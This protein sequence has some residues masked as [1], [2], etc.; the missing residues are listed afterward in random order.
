PA[1]LR[2]LLVLLVFG[3]GV[4]CAVQAGK[5]SSP[6]MGFGAA[7]LLI[8]FSILLLTAR[9]TPT[10]HPPQILLFAGLDLSSNSQGVGIF[11]KGYFYNYREDIQN[12]FSDIA[13]VTRENAEKVATVFGQDPKVIF[14]D[15]VNPIEGK[16]WRNFF[17]GKMALDAE[18]WT[19]TGARGVALA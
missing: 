7:L 1:V 18:V 9:P 12:K 11:Y 6:G 3:A 19:L 8:P 17:P 10:R 13:R 14:A 2:W 15:G 4:W 5:R 16:N